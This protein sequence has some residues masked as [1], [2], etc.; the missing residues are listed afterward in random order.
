MTTAPG[1][2]IIEN[3]ITVKASADEIWWALTDS[4][5]LENWWGDG[6]MLEARVGG[7]FR[8]PWEDDLGK[9]QLASGQV[10]ACKPK[11][12]IHFTW[13]E[14]NWPVGVETQC[15]FVIADQ[16]KLRVVT[17]QHSGWEKFPADSRE[18]TFKDFQIGWGYHLKEL[19]AYLDDEG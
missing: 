8:E 15:S 17:L 9:K 2:N 12:E 10:T 1:K 11:K 14:K 6:I 4:D 3:S 5:E 19:K 13:R 16:G 18:K 7:K